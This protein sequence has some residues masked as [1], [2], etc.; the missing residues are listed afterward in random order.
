MTDKQM[1]KILLKWANNENKL[2]EKIK[3]LEKEL[4]ILRRLP[5]PEDFEQEFQKG[6]CKKC[7][8]LKI[9]FALAKVHAEEKK[10]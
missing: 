2:K 3:L 4:F 7:K 5:T 6:L 8:I 10:K 1:E 9:K